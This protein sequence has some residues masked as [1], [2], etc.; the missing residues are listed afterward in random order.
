MEFISS[1]L[2]AVIPILVGYILNTHYKRILKIREKQL[3]DAY[4][5]LKL[6]LFKYDIEKD[7]ESMKKSLKKIYTK[8]YVLLESRDRRKI[9]KVIMGNAEGKHESELTGLSESAE[10]FIDKARRSIGYAGKSIS[11]IGLNIVWAALVLYVAL[12]VL[13]MLSPYVTKI[14]QNISAITII[15]GT[16]VVVGLITGCVC[17]V[18]G[19]GMDIY[20]FWKE[21][22][23]R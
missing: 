2:L 4:A 6:A 3:K 16:L 12:I 10:L 23:E 13:I 15:I 21:K 11:D 19:A 17:A 8:S 22:R 14:N 7:F 1:I 18:I 20:N 5:P 9:E